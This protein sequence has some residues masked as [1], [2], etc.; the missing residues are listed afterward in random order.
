MEHAFTPLEPLLPTG[1]VLPPKVH[2][3][4]PWHASHLSSVP[5]VAPLHLIPPPPPN[6]E[7]F[8]LGC[9]LRTL[10][11][12]SECHR[13]MPLASLAENSAL[14]AE[15]ARAIFRTPKNTCNV[16]GTCNLDVTRSH[17]VFAKALEGPR[18]RQEEMN[19]VAL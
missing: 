9:K 19:P 16:D 6:S 4:R 1:T 2:T 15:M 8:S 13:G 11:T 12:N 10:Q 3:D 14:P 18:L 7:L 17:S 5:G